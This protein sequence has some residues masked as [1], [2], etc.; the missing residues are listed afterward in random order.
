MTN[1]ILD[2]RKVL[3]VIICKNESEAQYHRDFFQTTQFIFPRANFF[4]PEVRFAIKN[5]SLAITCN[6]VRKNT[7][8][9]YLIFL[10]A[11]A[12][13]FD[14]A[15]PAKI[16]E[17]FFVYPKVG[18]VGLL[19]S[20]IP[21]RA[22]LSQAKNIYGAYFYKDGGG[23]IQHYGGKIPLLYQSVHVVDSGFFA[24]SEDILF[25]EDIGDEFFLAAQCCRYRQAGYDVG[26]MYLEADAPIFSEDR[27]IYRPQS[28]SDYEQ[29][30]NIFK[31]R[32]K[33]V[34]L[35]LV[36]IC[37]PTYNQ[38]RFFEMALQSALSQTYQLRR[39]TPGFSCGDISRRKK[40]PK[41]FCRPII[42]K[43]IK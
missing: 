42:R 36:S 29:Q 4:K 41:Y 14:A 17:M 22:N 5:R 35:P 19:G 27:C 15:L 7:D 6:D 26:V 8:A 20:E 32:Y 40:L 10:T 1:K 31:T 39:K 28:G 33:D 2:E 13:K 18:V 23:N 16:F 24:T 9:K 38:P 3:L 30:L 11:P 34:V 37:I 21:L 43:K 25:D 12:I